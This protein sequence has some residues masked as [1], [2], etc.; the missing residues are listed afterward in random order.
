VEQESL[1][2][3]K[4][5][6]R[7]SACM[8]APSEEIYYKSTQGNVEKYIQWVTNAVAGN[9]GLYSCTW[10]LLAPKSAK[11]RTILSKIRTDNSSGSSK[12]IDLGISRKR[13]CNS[14]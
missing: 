7:S 5:S 6:A 14:Y 3:A 10:L 11:S 8:K 1:A 4:V 12:V 9:T 2:N 13:I